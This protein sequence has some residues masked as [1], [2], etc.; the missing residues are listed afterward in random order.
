[1]KKKLFILLGI[2]IALAL[3]GFVILKI[4][5]K[6]AERHVATEK[7]IVIDAASL[8]AAFNAS[9]D[10]ANKI[11]LNKTLEVSG[12]AVSIDSNDDHQPVILLKA[13]GNLPGILCTFQQQVN[14]VQ[15][16]SMVTI[17][18]I[19]TG[20]LSNVALTDC[21]LL[22]SKAPVT[23]ITVTDTLKK[24]TDTVATVNPGPVTTNSVQVYSTSKAQISLDAGGGVEDIKAVNS[25]AD[26]TITSDGN[27]KFKVAILGFKFSDA[28][29]QE[30][31]NNSYLESKKYPTAS[32]TGKIGNMK[33]IDLAKDG[34]YNVNVSGDLTMHGITQKIST[35]ATLVVRNGKLSAKSSLKVKMDDYKISDDATESA[36]LSISANF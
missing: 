34:T 14:N 22:S 35:P 17:K 1:M 18:G 20:F 9:E 36:V 6:N 7:G 11:Y 10:S 3:I 31:F 4:M 25:Q 33:D 28:L 15:P 29:M 19:C 27:I 21:I 32:F 5:T 24:K 8:A 12:T 30:H 23:D 13:P 26:A 2:I 16:G